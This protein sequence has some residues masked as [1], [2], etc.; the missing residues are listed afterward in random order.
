MPVSH[1]KI[2][3]GVMAIGKTPAPL[4]RPTSEER[5]KVMLVIVFKERA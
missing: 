2:G 4:Q 5:E 3:D 1:G